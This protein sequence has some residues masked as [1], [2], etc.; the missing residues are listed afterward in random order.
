MRWKILM[1]RHLKLCDR[2]GRGGEQGGREVS[3]GDCPLPPAPTSHPPISII[4]GAASPWDAGNEGRPPVWVPCTPRTPSAAPARPHRAGGGT[5]TPPTP[6]VPPGA[7]PPPPN[8]L[9]GTGTGLGAAPTAARQG[10][11]QPPR[12]ICI[13]LHTA[14]PRGASAAPP[15]GGA[16]EARPHPLRR[17]R[18]PRLPVAVVTADVTGA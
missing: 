13:F 7:I 4:P 17:P 18:P 12:L 15:R 2:R 11:P 16:G 3:P 1:V 6:P 9:L 14:A 8:P 10:A 5:R